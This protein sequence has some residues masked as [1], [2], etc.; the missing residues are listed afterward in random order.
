LTPPKLILF[1]CDGVLVDSEP[2]TNA[3]LIKDLARYG[4]NLTMADCDDLFVG[5]TMVGAA[6]TAR[7]LG[8]NLPEDWV[9][10]YY[11]RVYEH[12]KQGVPLVKGISEILSQISRLGIPSGIV[13]NGSEEKMQIT[14]GPHGLWQ[15]FQGAI[16]SAH[17]HN[18]AKPDPELLWIAAR[19]FNTAPADCLFID[20]SP[21]GCTGAANAGMRCIGFAE[22]TNPDK[23]AATGATVIGSMAELP[24]LLGL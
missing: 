12:L 18:T 5:G 21:T 4:L 7:K 23:L 1:D 2:I 6:K 14:L 20:D 17:T 22:H 19:Q 10:D 24:A 3:F 8:A 15:H 13:S 16:F 9:D 11:H